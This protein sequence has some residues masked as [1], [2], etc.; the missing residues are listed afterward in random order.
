MKQHARYI[1]RGQGGSLGH[2]NMNHWDLTEIVKARS[3]KFRREMDKIESKEA[4]Y[5]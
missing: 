2:S 1:D 3:N 4:E 5:E